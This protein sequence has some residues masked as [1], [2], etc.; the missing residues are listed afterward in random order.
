MATSLKLGLV[1]SLFRTLF[2]IF[3]IDSVAP[4]TV[5]VYNDEIADTANL[6]VIDGL[7]DGILEIEQLIKI[8]DVNYI[9]AAEGWR[10]F[11]SNNNAIIS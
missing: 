11:D 4:S 9:N 1:F 10:F 2:K 5:V 7:M 3:L 6:I 8:V